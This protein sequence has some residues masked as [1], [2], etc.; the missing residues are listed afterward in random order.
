MKKNINKLKDSQKKLEKKR[1]FSFSKAFSWLF[2]LG[3]LALLPYIYYRMEI[4][5]SGMMNERYINYFIFA[6]AGIFFWV[7]VLNLKE[8]IR[9]NI[10]MVFISLV[11]GLYLV[12]AILESRSG[13]LDSH[14]GLEVLEDL[15]EQGVD[16]YP[17]VVP[18]H[19]MHQ[20]GL[21]KAEAELLFPF[22]GISEKTTVF[23]S[24]SGPHV[25]YASDRYGFN[26][27][28]SMWNSEQIEWLLTGDSFIQGACVEPDDNIAGQ[29][30]LLTNESVA[31]LG[32]SGNGP[33]VELA[34]LKE[35]AE[36]VSPKKVLWFYYEGNDLIMDLS[37]E[38]D[39]PLLMQYLQRGFS[40]NLIRQQREIDNRL[41][42]YVL[43]SKDEARRNAFN[44]KTRWLRLFAV[45]S[46]LSFSEKTAWFDF[47]GY[48]GEP[49]LDPVF[50]SILTAA[51]DRT[52]AWGGEL[53][54][55]YLP[56]FLRYKTNVDHNLFRKRSEVIEL[57][58]KLNIPVIDIHKEVFSGHADPLSLFPLRRYGHYTPDG[59]SQVA[60]AIVTT[61][62]NKGAMPSEQ[63][64]IP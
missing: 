60:E 25:I 40:Q 39:I 62:S 3:F 18:S 46:L 33:L 23:C 57:V 14:S 22:G 21:P 20:G 6:F 58:E 37:A 47:S 11:I 48:A 19:F 16:A 45:R 28:D 10:L 41:A 38:K 26:N 36:P 52:K 4:I 54:F 55:I 15:I 24:E 56:E 44:H 12:E 64:T 8:E 61:I 63:T 17:T 30:R 34:V 13:E 51:N 32:A 53:Y 42:T 43:K 31:N 7:L 9:N 1:Y 49:V 5:N 50:A 59:Y 27:P 35:Y 2:L 29:I